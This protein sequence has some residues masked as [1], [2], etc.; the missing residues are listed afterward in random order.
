MTESK[1][2]RPS[3]PR[4]GEP[5]PDIDQFQPPG[6]QPEALLAI[7]WRGKW[8]VVGSGLLIALVALILVMRMPDIYRAEVVLAVAEQ[9]RGDTLA[10][11]G[12]QLG[13]LAQFAGLGLLSGAAGVDKAQ[14]ALEVLRSRAFLGDFIE[15][16][17]LLVPLMAARGW[18]RDRDA[19]LLD[20]SIYSPAEQR[21]L[22]EPRPPRT[23]EPSLQEAHGALLDRLRIDFDRPR[24]VVTVQ[25][26]YYSPFVAQ[27]WLARLVADLNDTMR[28][29]D[30]ELARNSIAY[31]EEQLGQTSVADIR[32][33]FFQLIE[34][35]LR[36]QMLA[37]V[38]PDYVFTIVDPPVPPELKHSPR[39]A[40]IVA[41]ALAAGLL[42]GMLLVV[43]SARLKA[44][45]R[46]L[47][48]S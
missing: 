20:E 39:R 42:L 4:Q 21:W 40:V 5:W 27:Q 12:S 33:V 2:L 28:K 37:E 45:Q 17:D 38:R 16:H 25:L 14:L 46:E 13:G 9:D 7:L 30:I 48:M 26:D 1:D 6:Y 31:I 23:A 24:G 41:I 3:T 36:T 32:Q 35:H 47:G 11:I 10:G 22:R 15:R 18:D 44:A 29:Q 19:L 8:L 43:I 34:R